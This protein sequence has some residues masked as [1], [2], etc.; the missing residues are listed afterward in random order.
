MILEQIM[1]EQIRAAL[2]ELVLDQGRNILRNPKACEK[3]LAAKLAQDSLECSLL[4]RCVRERI[5]QELLDARVPLQLQVARLARRLEKVSA[6]RFEVARWAVETWAYALGI[7][8][9]E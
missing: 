1:D 7:K 5:P 9:G 3:L 8:A 4:R 2:R 6:V